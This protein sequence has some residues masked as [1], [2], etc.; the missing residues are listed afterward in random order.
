MKPKFNIGDIVECPFSGEVEGVPVVV[1][2]RL[3]VQGVRLMALN[4]LY[5]I[6][7]NDPMKYSTIGRFYERPEPELI[8]LEPVVQEIE[9]NNRQFIAET[10][11][12]QHAQ[13]L[14]A[15]QSAQQIAADPIPNYWSSAGTACN[16]LHD[17]AA[18]SNAI[19]G[20]RDILH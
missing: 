11:L 6:C 16:G 14:K 18:L 7:E 19:A 5:G 8:E 12:N 15:L 13:I 2:K 17:Y 10:Q 20:R 9:R 3:F 1:R 4:F